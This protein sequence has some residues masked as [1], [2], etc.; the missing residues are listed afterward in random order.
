MCY[1][2]ENEVKSYTIRR[3]IDVNNTQFSNSFMFREYRFK[4]SYRYTDARSGA[5]MHYI[6]C[7]RKGHCRIVSEEGTIEVSRGEVFYLPKNLRYQSYWYGEDSI[8]FDSFGFQFFPNPEERSYPLQII[9][10][11]PT[12]LQLADQVKAYE[13]TSGGAIFAF[14]KLLEQLLPRMTYVDTS[15]KILLK[16][17][18]YLISDPFAQVADVAKACDISPSGLYAV[19][20]RSGEITPNSLR[21]KVLVDK[22]VQ[23]LAETDIPV[24]E[25]SSRLRFSSTAYFRKVLKKYTGLTP[26]QIRKKSLF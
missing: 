25:I 22:A 10:S 11:T 3:K 4:K 21:Q 6:A 9:S 5:Q 23:M 26:S 1:P 17:E 2:T 15:N 12:D 20:K 19:F 8:C 13:E 18:R 24:E 7:M 14:F 16:A